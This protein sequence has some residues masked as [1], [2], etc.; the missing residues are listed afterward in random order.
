MQATDSPP[1]Q[2][3]I[4]LHR[5][6]C[7][8]IVQIPEEPNVVTISEDK[9][10]TVWTL[11]GSTAVPVFHLPFRSTPT[12][13]C[14]CPSLKLFAI[15]HDNGTISLIAYSPRL[16]TI[17]LTIQAHSKHV[18]GIFFDSSSNRFFSVSHDKKLTCFPCPD[19]SSLPISSP[20]L[21]SLQVSTSWPGCITVAGSRVFV[22]TYNREVVV[23]NVTA[24]NELTIA[25]TLHGHKGSIRT[26]IFDPI[27]SYLMTGS[28]DKL[29]FIWDT[30]TRLLSSI[31]PIACLAA[32]EKKVKAMSLEVEERLLVCGDDAGT[33]T[34]HDL[35]TGKRLRHFKASPHKILSLSLSKNRMISGDSKGVVRVWDLTVEKE[36]KLEGFSGV[37]EEDFEVTSESEEEKVEV[38][39]CVVENSSENF[40][41]P[42]VSVDTVDCVVDAEEVKEEFEVVQDIQ[43]VEET[44]D[45]SREDEEKIKENEVESEILD[46]IIEVVDRN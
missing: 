22:G 11:S 26:C 31:R 46:G 45:E 14:Y 10:C 3:H 39:V 43:E 6:A 33:I 23:V 9:T 28:F 41:E 38:R 19:M 34:V 15:G 25:T 13:I 29:V 18:S 24:E 40:E 21:S 5:K 12:T 44:V 20:P 7:L 2:T 27:T 35:R 1:T 4:L 16:L 30:S 36:V 37:A 32:H 42:V 17:L 8:G